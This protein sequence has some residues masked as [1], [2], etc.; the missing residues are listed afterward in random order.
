MERLLTEEQ[1]EQLV[2][3]VAKRIREPQIEE[4]NRR[5]EPSELLVEIYNELEDCSPAE[6]LRARSA[7]ELY[8]NLK[9]I[10]DRGLRREDLSLFQDSVEQ[11]RKLAVYELRITKQRENNAKRTQKTILDTG[12]VLSRKFLTS[13]R[14]K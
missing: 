4:N 9:Y 14:D 1:F 13:K 8:E 6:L 3:E 10:A 5:S 2:A 7:A 11:C 12:E